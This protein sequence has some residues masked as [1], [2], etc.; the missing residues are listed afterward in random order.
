MA[1]SLAV[2]ATIELRPAGSLSGVIAGKAT[3]NFRPPLAGGEVVPRLRGGTAYSGQDAGARAGASRFELFLTALTLGEPRTAE[4]PLLAERDRALRG[5]WPDRPPASASRATSAA[6]PAAKTAWQ[7]LNDL[8]HPAPPPE[9]HRADGD[10]ADS[11]LDDFGG[12][13]SEGETI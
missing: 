7:L 11:R 12:R 10:S 2:M 6:G 9:N 13:Y 4:A 5:Q 3:E 1:A 8:L